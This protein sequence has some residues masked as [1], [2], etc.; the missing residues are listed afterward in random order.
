[1]ELLNLR[2]LKLHD[3]ILLDNVEAV[4]IWRSHSDTTDG[5]LYETPV[6]CICSNR[7]NPNLPASEADNSYYLFQIVEETREYELMMIGA[8]YG[9]VVRKGEELEDAYSNRTYL[10]TGETPSVKSPKSV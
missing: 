8:D 1:M 4:Q 2:D 3:K 7:Y 5:L 6:L 9:Q 10:E